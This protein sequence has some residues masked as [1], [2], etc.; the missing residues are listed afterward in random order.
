MVIPKKCR[1]NLIE[2]FSILKVKRMTLIK[3][4]GFESLTFR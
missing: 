3:F 4:R 2:I 1:G